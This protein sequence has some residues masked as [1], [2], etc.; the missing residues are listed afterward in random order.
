MRRSLRFKNAS[1]QNEALNPQAMSEPHALSVVW[2]RKVM[3]MRMLQILALL[4]T[5]LALVPAGAHFFEFP[6]KINLSRESYFTV[7]NLYR[8]WQFF[9]IA[10]VGALLLNGVLAFMLRGEGQTFGYALAACLLLL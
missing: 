2:M 9:G 4:V 3:A 7:Q 10:V 6:N 8:G 5:A 1:L